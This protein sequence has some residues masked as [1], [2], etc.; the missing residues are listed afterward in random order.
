MGRAD[1]TGPVAVAALLL[2]RI[3]LV[4]DTKQ[5]EQRAEIYK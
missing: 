3:S 5:I 2:T 4:P 1:L